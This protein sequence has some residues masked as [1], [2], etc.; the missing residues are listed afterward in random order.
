MLSKAKVKAERFDRF[1]IIK[2]QLIINPACPQY[3][4]YWMLLEIKKVVVRKNY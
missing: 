3:N 1:S 4:M 2:S